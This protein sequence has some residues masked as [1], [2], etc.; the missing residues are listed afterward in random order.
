VVACTANAH[1]EPGIFIDEQGSELDA[2]GTATITWNGQT[3]TAEGALNISRF[4]Q[5]TRLPAGYGGGRI[6]G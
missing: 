5:T 4:S 1:P 3:R 6:A 2:L